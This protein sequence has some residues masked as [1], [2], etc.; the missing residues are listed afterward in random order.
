MLIAC[1][2]VEQFASLCNFLIKPFS[3]MKG[4][5][6]LGYARG[7]VGDVVFSRS[8]GQQQ[9]RARNRRPNNPRTSRQM[10]QRSLFANAVKFHTRGVQ[11][12]FKFAFEDKRA[13]E[14]DYNA[15]MK[16]NMNRGVRISRQASQSPV[17]PA[18][19]NWQMSC[20]SI[21]SPR[22]SFEIP[23]KTWRLQ[24]PGLSSNV[25]TW[26]GLFA[27]LKQVYGLQ[28]G[29]I[30]TTVHIVANGATSSNVPSIEP[31]SGLEGS[32]WNIYQYLVDSSSTAELP[33]TIECDNG[34]VVIT[35]STT[36]IDTYCQGYC[37]IF[38]RK[39]ASG[40]K[41]SSSYLVNNAVADTCITQ[42][43]EPPFVELVLQSWDTS[44]DVILEGSLLPS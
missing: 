22:M 12:L 16:H 13:N 3:P 32:D 19:G 36:S 37:W 40:L 29:D 5:M 8:N 18:L 25:T 11:R 43:Q 14:S 34:F 6:F 20:G 7:S 2:S 31:D 33:S 24:V 9:G 30:I 27:A 10:R 17:Y 15:F 26:G 44:E 38:S 28:E 42:S 39:A 4:N 21:E 23:S 41:V 35:A 1:I